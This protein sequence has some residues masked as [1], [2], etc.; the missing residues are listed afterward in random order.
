M[1][2]AITPLQDLFDVAVKSLP[3]IEKEEVFIVRDLF[4]GFEWNRIKK[5][6]RTKLGSMFYA[7]AQGSGA[8]YIKPI[9]KTPQNQQLYKKL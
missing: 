4:R 9:Q 2:T 6:N 1:I 5:G 3:D 7:Y 8:S